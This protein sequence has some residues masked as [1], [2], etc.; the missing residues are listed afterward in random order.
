VK[1][2]FAIFGMD[3][4]LHARARI[5]LNGGKDTSRRVI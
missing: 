4:W 1:Q 3:F 2:Y 5:F